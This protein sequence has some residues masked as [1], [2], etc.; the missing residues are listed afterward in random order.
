MNTDSANQSILTI[1]AVLQLLHDQNYRL[2][3]ELA[4]LRDIIARSPGLSE[5]SA[6]WFKDLPDKL[7]RAPDVERYESGFKNWTTDKVPFKDWGLVEHEAQQVLIDD[8]RQALAP[9]SPTP[10]VVVATRIHEAIDAALRRIETQP[11]DNSLP[12]A[13]GPDDLA[14]DKGA[15]A[16]MV[17]EEARIPVAARPPVA[18]FTLNAKDLKTILDA[19]EGPPPT[20]TPAEL[21]D[22]ALLQ[23]HTGQRR[24]VK[25]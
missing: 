17:W 5:S 8:L 25:P 21:E 23:A 13:P 6:W 12:D 15:W 19:L 11:P 2:S 10:G 7:G 3:K 9:Q 14:P 20:K 18:P 22:D 4:R 16:D 24:I 1:L